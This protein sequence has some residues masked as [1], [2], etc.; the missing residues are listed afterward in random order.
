MKPPSPTLPP[1]C[2]ST[3][4]SKSSFRNPSSFLCMATIDFEKL[5]AKFDPSDLEWR[6]GQA[7]ESNGKVWATALAYLT[8]RAVM[9]RLDEACGP[10]NWRNE[11]TA[12]PS[13]GVLCG[14]SIKI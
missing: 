5:K 1:R 8:S 4:P 11:Y 9:D 12:G 3:L 10:E 6:I 14:I 7:G 13:G 2:T